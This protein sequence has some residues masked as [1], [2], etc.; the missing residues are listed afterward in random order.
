VYTIRLNSSGTAYICDYAVGG[1]SSVI[2]TIP[3]F[4]TSPGSGPGTVLYDNASQSPSYINGVYVASLAVDDSTLY[5]GNADSTSNEQFI[6]LPLSSP[7]VPCFARGTNILCFVDNEDRY[8][9]IEDLKKGTLVKTWNRGYRK[10]EKIGVSKHGSFRMCKFSTDDFDDLTDDLYITHNHAVL[11]RQ[12][13]DR[14]RDQLNLFYGRIKVTEGFYRVPACF[15]PGASEVND[16][17]RFTEVYHFALETP[18]KNENFGVYANGML[19][20]TLFLSD[21]EKQRLVEIPSSP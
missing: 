12:I 8:L 20:E 21:F 4:I 13:S 7:P 2:Y 9:P 15:A 17:S 3:N 14:E 10:I 6:V 5:L 11:K 18:N 19:V 16:N 1:T